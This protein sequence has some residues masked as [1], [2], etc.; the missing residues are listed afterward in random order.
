M[1]L[2]DSSAM[3][4]GMRAAPLRRLHAFGPSAVCRGTAAVLVNLA[5]VLLGFASVAAALAA[6]QGSVPSPAADPA[7]TVSLTYQE[8]SYSV[9]NW[10]TVV[11][12]QAAPFKKEPAFGSRK[13]LRGTLQFGNNSE[14]AIPFAW[15][16]SE[17]KLYLDLNRNQ[18][19]T[20]DPHGVFSSSN[21]RQGSNYYQTFTDVHLSFK[22][23]AGSYQ[24][25][26]D[27][28]LY[29]FGDRLSGNAACRSIWTGRAT[30]QGSDWQVG[31]V[32]N[33]SGTVGSAASGY[34]LVRPWAAREQPF[35]LDFQNGGLDGFLFSPNL[36]F[37]GH[38]YQ[39]ACDYVAQGGPPH[40][41]LRLKEQPVELGE[42]KLT[43]R[44]INRLVLTGSRG[45]PARER[46]TVILDSP[47]PV[48]KIPTGS[49]GE[50]RVGLKAGGVEA[51]RELNRY[52][53]PPSKPTVVLGNGAP[54]VL[55][56]GGPLT[57]SVSVNR[58]GRRLAL[59][60]QLVGADGARYQLPGNDRLHPPEFAIAKDGKV[61]A[62]GKFEFG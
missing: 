26:V 27:L 8:L 45:A 42:L 32:E 17:G 16:R 29:S 47:Q 39:A 28:N 23:P 60:Y 61:I 36:F 54:A 5:A 43:G 21:P 33:F 50:C 31:I 53:G 62:S 3:R 13:V 44:F 22:T 59:S 58:E 52:G 15:D 35:H 14:Q 46:M 19:L 51:C 38:A 7:Q 48:V 9:V 2:A 49:Y 4:P 57:N 25:L 41:N 40:F 34:M 55:A 24:A 20:D 1:K 37:G 18:D 11:N 30:L 56:A 12:L 6:P 10:G